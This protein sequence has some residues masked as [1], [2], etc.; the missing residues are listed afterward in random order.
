MEKKSTRKME[1]T[2]EDKVEG[3]EDEEETNKAMEKK[4]KGISFY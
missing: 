4:D 3:T 2:K 1:K